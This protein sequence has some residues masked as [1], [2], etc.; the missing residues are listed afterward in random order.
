MT[1]A[2]LFE[3]TSCLACGKSMQWVPGT[4]PGTPR[5]SAACAK[6][7]AA[8]A[9]Y[10]RLLLVAPNRRDAS[11]N[12]L[13]TYAMRAPALHRLTRQAI[14]I[15]FEEHRA[16][17][18]LCSCGDAGPHK[19]NLHHRFYRLTFTCNACSRT[20]GPVGAQYLT[21]AANKAAKVAR[22]VQR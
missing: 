18:V 7:C 1:P 4:T 19:T 16:G 12:D 5:C 11:I 13:M 2:A 17:V 9:W 8:V 10:R 15:D 20:W 21:D 3:A 6:P 14:L 22:K